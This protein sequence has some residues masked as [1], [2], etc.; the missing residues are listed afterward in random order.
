MEF[1]IIN[2]QQY[3]E[4]KNSFE[5][6][7]INY[8]DE[9]KDCIKNFNIENFGNY[10]SY[11]TIDNLEGF[12]KNIGTNNEDDIKIIIK[13][14]NKLLK[15]ILGG[16]NTNFYWISIRIHSKD[17][18]FDIP[19]WHCDGYYFSNRN[20]LQ[21]KFITT[22]KGPTTL[23]L[24]TSPEEKEHFLKLDPYVDQFDKNKRKYISENIKGTKIKIT[25]NQ[26]LIFAAGDKDKC[27]IHSEPKFD[28]NR[29]FISILPGNK[30]DIDELSERTNKKQKM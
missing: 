9:E 2:I 20:I 22:L 14:I 18:F 8:T 24:K 23:I 7:D 10:N 17:D 12:I 4:S 16:Y 21:S 6:F 28:D 25:N 30:S 5:I 26:G 29:I 1:N 11:N 19:R 3:I 15:N 13:I 27:L